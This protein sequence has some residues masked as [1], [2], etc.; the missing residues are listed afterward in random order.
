M[1]TE[2]LVSRMLKRFKD[3]LVFS[4]IQC[5]L[6]LVLYF[7]LIPSVLAGGINSFSSTLNTLGS[8]EIEALDK[9]CTNNNESACVSLEDHFI[10]R[11]DNY[12]YLKY[13]KKSCNL[14][15][16]I[17][18]KLYNE[19]MIYLVCLFFAPL[20]L[21]FGIAKIKKYIIKYRYLCFLYVLIAT[22]LIY[23]SHS[24]F[25]S[26]LTVLNIY[27]GTVWANFLYYPLFLFPL[28]YYFLRQQHLR[29][30]I[31]RFFSGK[32]RTI[33]QLFLVLTLYKAISFHFLFLLK[34]YLSPGSGV[35]LYKSN[36]FDSIY[37]LTA[38]VFSPIFE[39]IFFKGFVF[40]YLWDWINNKKVVLIFS[41]LVFVLIHGYLIQGLFALG[42][43]FITF[44]FYFY[45]RENLWPV[46]IAHI[47]SNAPSH[48]IM[49]VKPFR[50]IFIEKMDSHEPLYSSGQL[51]VLILLFIFMMF[52]FVRTLRTSSSNRTS[53]LVQNTSGL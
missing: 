37:L 14:G 11:G 24:F 47:L 41:V 16:A 40:N 33:L 32:T 25:I 22:T 34:E 8:K 36:F 28:T 51:S 53:L 23:I 21:F 43:A 52:V 6:L 1:L 18:C 46:I 27:P 4:N 49:R 38:V 5:L 45:H 7:T 48:I 2:Q 17:S 39:E 30:E 29:F 13:S 3:T 10:Q 19:M 26:L 35:L 9:S 20:L 12:R 50:E 42:F 44:T 31:K 15:N